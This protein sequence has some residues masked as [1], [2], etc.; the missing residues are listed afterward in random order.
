MTHVECPQRTAL[1]E[2]NRHTPNGSSRLLPHRARDCTRG[3]TKSP[4]PGQ[5]PQQPRPGGTTLTGPGMPSELEARHVAAPVYRHAE[6]L[7][8]G[9]KPGL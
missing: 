9:G 8:L 7:D 2:Y 5:G 1:Q 4:T 6:Q 3:D